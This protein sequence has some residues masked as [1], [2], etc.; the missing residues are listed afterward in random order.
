MEEATVFNVQRFSTE[1]GPGIRTTVFFKGCPLKCLWCHNPEGMSPKP[2]IMWYDVRCI[3]ARDCLTACPEGA[4]ELTKQGMNID[5]GK[6]RGCGDCAEACPAAALELIGKK[7]TLEALLEEAGRDRAFYG[8]SGG[9]VT[10]SGG[11]PLMQHKFVMAFMAAC[12]GAGMHVALDTSG[13]ASPDVFEPAA[14]A[15]DMVLLDLKHMA[16][17]RSLELAG[18]P[19]EPI[20]RNARWLGGTGKPVWVRTPVIPGATDENGNVAAIA[21]FIVKYL[22]NCERYDLLPFSNL[23]SSKYKRLDQVFPYEKTPLVSEERM[24]ELKALAESRGVK[25]VVASG[26]MAGKKTGIVP[27]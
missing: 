6:C 21:D 10:L 27:Q 18:V 23:C 24:A 4:L 26:M 5:R 13:Y 16:P 14:A 12:R 2:Q 11:E 1:D 20:L 15:A 3:G 22:P 17:D 19:V 8:N 9:G 7:W 25:N